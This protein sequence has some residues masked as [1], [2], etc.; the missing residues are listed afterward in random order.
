M[1]DERRKWQDPEK[2]IKSVGVRE[3]MVV[4]DLGCGPG[5]FTIPLALAVG[6]SGI[7][8]AVDSNSE[9][10]SYLRA[11]LQKLGSAPSGLVKIIEADVTKTKIPLNSVDIAF[12]ANIL[13]DLAE[14]S[15]FL[16]EVSRI[17]RKDSVIVDI[18]WKKMESGFGPPLEMR[19]SAGQ[20][21]QI[22]H[23][24]G[25]EVTK[26]VY[27]GRFHYGLVC[28][29]TRRREINPRAL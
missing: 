11:N 17:I 21:K 8:Y 16:G 6:K 2:T 26:S 25:F 28:R 13:H 7:V 15:A 5:F 4:A 9:M 29:L 19:L 12:F 1:L 18:D 20:S 14:P 22:L 3:K 27:A 10:L 23:R 24:A